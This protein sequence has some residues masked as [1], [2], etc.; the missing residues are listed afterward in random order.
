MSHIRDR[1]G[2]VLLAVMVAAGC[3][4][5][6]LRPENRAAET[7]DSAVREEPRI[8][9]P[10]QKPEIALASEER[11]TER[12][13]VLA[14]ETV[15]SPQALPAEEVKPRIFGSLLDDSGTHIA[16]VWYAAVSLVNVQGERRI[17]DAKTEDNYTFDNLEFG[18]YWL[19]GGAEGFSNIEVSVELRPECPVVRQDFRLHRQVELRIRASTPE[20]R[21]LFEALNERK[22]PMETRLL[23]PVATRENP[24]ARFD[25]V[26]GSLNNKFGVGRFWNYGPRVEEL[27]PGYM[28]ILQLDGDL[29]MWVSLMHHHSVLQAKFVEAGQEEV[30]FVLSTDDVLAD[31]A[32]IRLRAIDAETS[33]P[34]AS[35]SV[36]LRGGPHFPGR[37]VTDSQ[38]AATIERHEPG[39][40]DLQIMAAGYE[41][42]RKPIDA[43]PG[44]LTDLGTIELEK[45]VTVRIRV[46]DSQGHPQA[47]DF[48]LGV[49]DPADRSIGWFKDAQFG[50]DEDGVLD[51]P[52][53]GRREYVMH[54]AN[55]DRINKPDS[56]PIAGVSGNVRF[57]SRA[58]S[59]VDLEVRVLPAAKMR[60]RVGDGPADGMKFRILDQNGLELLRSTFHG[61]APRALALPKG[62]YRVFLLDS[63]G[64]VLSEQPAILGAGGLEL[65]LSR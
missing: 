1:F 16:N 33:A 6:F 2:L 38:G 12:V 23:V 5:I 44:K 62:T 65:S 52:G 8:A 60:I 9:R 25:D 39:L 26:A 46:V 27:P 50:C 10:G 24:G 41:W 20:G 18:I 11:A 42:F 21:N 64:T 54:S 13:A 31:V 7:P 63:D 17:C 3:M 45:E 37:I 28:G 55:I 53:L 4:W 61:S 48:I 30:N 14:P 59:I 29:P 35:A 43:L 32:T 40:F 49:I 58:G 19:T 34:I 36:Q 47:M 15:P 51:L 22:A 57:D 56:E